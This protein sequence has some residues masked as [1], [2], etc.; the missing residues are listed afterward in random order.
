MRK[1]VQQHN[2]D[3]R[4]HVVEADLDPARHGDHGGKTYECPPRTIGARRLSILGRPGARFRRTLD[5]GPLDSLPLY[6]DSDVAVERFFRSIA[7]SAA[8]ALDTE[9]ASFHRYLDRIYLLQVS[10]PERHAI[11]DPL[12][13]QT[14]QP[15]GALLESPAVEVVF[16]DADYDLRLLHQDYGWRVTRIF[17]TRIAAQLLGIRAFGLAALLE[18]YFGVRLDKKH[19]RADWSMRPLPADM[20][21]YAAQDTMY[22]LRLREQLREAL[23]HKN[24]WTW[25]LEE[26]ER[27][28]GTRW[29]EGDPDAAFLRLKGARELSR[30]ELALLRELVVWRDAVARRLDRS[31]FRVAGNEVL[32]ELARTSPSSLDVLER[33]KGLARSIVARFGADLVAALERGR[34]VP[35]SELPRFPKGLRW[36]RDTEY[37]DRVIRLKAVRDRVAGELELD[38]GV[39]CPRER[40]EAVARRNP[41]NANQLAEVPELRRWQAELLGED[42]LRSLHDGATTASPHRERGE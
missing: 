27:L 13:V 30:R 7:R 22:L 32:F 8:L 20:L 18:K 25:A 12:C 4:S 17:D 15:L 1:A 23:E 24:R 31:T 9:G 39:L 11:I 37:E 16:H 14:L 19:Q 6:L 40:L 26:F 5:S 29:E 10:T 21:H 38:P 42:F 3:S 41:E 2:R 33:T 35:E 36:A 28:E 34:A